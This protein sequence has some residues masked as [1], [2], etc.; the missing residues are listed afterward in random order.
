MPIEDE[1]LEGWP[2]YETVQAEW[3]AAAAAQIRAAA[4]AQ[5]AVR[6][7]DLDNPLSGFVGQRH[8]Q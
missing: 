8:R 2:A 1:D 4:R 5:G 6:L 7:D 3:A